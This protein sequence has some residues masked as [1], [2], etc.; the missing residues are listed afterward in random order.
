[1]TVMTQPKWAAALVE[2]LQQ[3]QELYEQLG[4]LGAEQTRLVQAGEPEPLIALLSR[5]QHLIDR[6]AA[7]SGQLE[8]YKQDWPRYWAQ[9]DGAM[10]RQ[11]TE[12]INRVQELLDQVMVRDEQDRSTLTDHRDR[13]KGD[14]NRMHRGANVNQAYRQTNPRAA[15][16]RF[17]DQQG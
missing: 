13:M 7:L 14:L 5:R 15:Q 6:L 11:V 16:P 2:N 8:P 12:L 1:M 3:Q 4:G 9:L 17:T 10:R